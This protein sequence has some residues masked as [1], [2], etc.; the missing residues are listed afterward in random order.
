MSIINLALQIVKKHSVYRSC[1]CPHHVIT[2]WAKLIKF[3]GCVHKYGMLFVN[4]IGYNWFLFWF[5]YRQINS[6]IHLFSICLKIKLFVFLYIQDF[7]S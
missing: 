3:F 7:L 1:R 6:I 2:I 4:R 5:L